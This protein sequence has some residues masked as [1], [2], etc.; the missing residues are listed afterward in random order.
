MVRT[1]KNVGT[2][3]YCEL[4]GALRAG[5]FARMTQIGGWPTRPK[6]KHAS[7]VKEDPMTATHAS[8]ESG[9]AAAMSRRVFMAGAAAAPL[10]AAWQ[11]R[12]ADPAA[13]DAKPT[14]AKRKVKLAVVGCGGRGSWIAKLFQQHGGY[15]MWA[16]ADYFQ[17]AADASGDALGVDKARRFTGLSSCKKVIESGAEAVVIIDVPCFYPEQARMAVEAGLHGLEV[18]SI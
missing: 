8:K 3:R 7:E 16:V 4:D 17:D 10:L 5:Y 6:G 1:S 2:L 11:A 15:E 18:K 9:S 14:E 13:A 12:A